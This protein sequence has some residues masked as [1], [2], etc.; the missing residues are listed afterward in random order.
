MES[1]VLRDTREG[2]GG[3]GFSETQDVDRTQ[4]CDLFR[5]SEYE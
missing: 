1:N 2:K 3:G 5:A 4:T